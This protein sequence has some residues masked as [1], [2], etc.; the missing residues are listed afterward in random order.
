VSAVDR[1][2]HPET[3]AIAAGR[4]TSPGAPLNVPPTFVSTF[5]DGPGGTPAAYGRSHNPTW[6]AFEAALGA[7]EGGSAVAFSSGQAAE[8]ALLADLPLGAR[9][10]GPET[11]YL[12]TRGLLGELARGGRLRVDLVD[13]TDTDAVLSVLDGADLLWLESPTNPLLGVA[14]LPALLAAATA[15]AVTCVVDNTFATPLLQRP[16]ALGAS[17]VVHSATK[18]L[19]GHSDLLLGAVVT[20][21]GDRH[22]ALVQHRNRQ[23]AI[24]GVMEAFLALRGL[25]TLPVRLA[26]QQATARALA[27]RLAAHPGVARVRYPGLPGDPHHQRARRQMSGPG[28]MVA[29]EVA[30]ALAAD[31]LVGSLRLIV[32]STSL[33]GVET[34]I[35]RRGRWPGEEAIPPG[36]LRMSVGLE[37]VDDLWADLEA[38]ITAA[39]HG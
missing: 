14:D 32:P 24:P 26:R 23:G 35:E 17:A 34:M 7:L 10:V 22:E 21:G 15:A 30:D 1:R 16:L 36:L 28:A 20:A 6:E 9:V 19:G 4:D 3:T 29:F 38:A 13:I 37:H 27:D 31:G 11:S 2:W 25:R 39:P 12:G 18:Y 5:R 8:V 33:G